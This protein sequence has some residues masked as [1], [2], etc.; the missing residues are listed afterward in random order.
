MVERSPISTSTRRRCSSS[1]AAA[2]AGNGLRRLVGPSAA[3]R[4]QAE[5]EPAL[6]ADSARPARPDG[7]Y[8][9]ERGMRL[10]ARFPPDKPVPL[11]G[12]C[13]AVGRRNNPP[14]P[15][16]IRA[17]AVYNPIHYQELPELFMDF[18]SSLTGKSPSTTG[19]GAKGR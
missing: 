7:L 3:G 10:S 19:A 15:A 18:I 5:Q 14:E 13:G 9:A 16:G 11:A 17:L 6:P 1:S 4:W 8:V 12:R 2:E